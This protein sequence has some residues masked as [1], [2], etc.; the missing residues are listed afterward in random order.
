MRIRRAAVAVAAVTAAVVGVPLTAS[1]TGSG[2]PDA[3]GLARAGT[4]LVKF[5]TDRPGKARSIGT[6]RGLV[7]DTKLVGID[8][9][10]QNGKLYG[11]G[12]RG[13]LYTL[14][15]RS[16]KATA[17]AIVACPQNGTSASGEK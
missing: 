2:G 7:G 4:A 13:G 3:V 16:A 10:V 9:R 6:V 15:T 1:A 17:V 11:V 5:D 8:R 12:D 14:S